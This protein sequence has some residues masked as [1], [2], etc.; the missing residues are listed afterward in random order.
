PTLTLQSGALT[1]FHE[2][3]AKFHAVSTAGAGMVVGLLYAAPKH[4]DV[5]KALADTREMGVDDMLYDLLPVNFKVFFKPGA[6]AAAWRASLNSLPR[7]DFNSLPY[8]RFWSDCLALAFRSKSPSD[9]SL[10]SLGLCD[11]APWIDEIVDFD[12]LR[13][14]FKGEFYI[15]AYCIE[16]QEMQIFTKDEIGAAHFRAA[17]AFPLIYPPF[18]LN[19]KTYIEGSALDTLCFKGLLRYR[20]KRL[21]QEKENETRRNKLA[22]LEPLEHVVVFDVLSSDRIIRKPK[23]LY[24]AWI[25]S[26]MIPLVEIAKDDIEIFQHKYNEPNPA[27]G[28]QG[29]GLK[30]HKLKFDIPD[31]QW[32]FVLD[33]SYS[34]LKTL[35][36][37]GYAAGDAFC[38]DPENSWLFETPEPRAGELRPGRAA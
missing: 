34:N 32:P 17:L 20:D 16:D 36:D 4:G 18:Q 9:L 27:T 26:I 8:G 31:Q 14:D 23:N 15:N 5:R 2:A 21:K 1:A 25:Q 24:D 3:D 30:L 33:W 35:Y 28:R 38:R 22:A 37:V 10:A 29:W 19:G 7:L 12:K 11:H 13:N 6:G